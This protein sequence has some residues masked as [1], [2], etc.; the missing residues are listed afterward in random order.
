MSFIIT[1]YRFNFIR[2]HRV[3]CT[4]Q[5][6]YIA[7]YENIKITKN[8][9]KYSN[10]SVQVK[11]SKFNIKRNQHL[12]PYTPYIIFRAERILAIDKKEKFG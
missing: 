3:I 11:L 10:E 2:N 7:C 1:K 12:K 9:L 8:N 6:L 4:F 5:K